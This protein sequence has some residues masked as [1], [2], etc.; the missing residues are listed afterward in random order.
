MAKG[1]GK[2]KAALTSQQ[3][4]LKKKQEAAHAEQVERAK[5]SARTKGKTKALA[6]KPT[7]PFDPTDRILL[8]GEG[9]FSFARALA[10]HPPSLLEYLPPSNITA[11]AYDSEEECYAKYPEAEGIVNTLRQKG[12]HVLFNV[13][14]AK[15]DKCVALKGTRWDKIVWNFP[16]AGMACCII[17]PSHGSRNSVDRKGHRRSGPQY[18]VQPSADCRFFP[19]CRP[20]PRNR[21][22]PR[23][24]ETS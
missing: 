3:T 13:D 10:F 5:Q 19:L 2:L 1:K 14:A 17:F 15:L 23:H 20:F 21:A 6:P 8:I 7:I 16:H 22:R 4:R 9:N 18:L 12:V 24:Y 11:T